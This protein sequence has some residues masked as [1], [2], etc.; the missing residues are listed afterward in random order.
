MEPRLIQIIELLRHI[1]TLLF[2][3]LGLIALLGGF[4][5]ADIVFGA[6]LQVSPTYSHFNYEGI[7]SGPGLKV[8]VSHDW[9]RLWGS[10]QHTCRTEH[11]QE[12]GKLELLGVG[13]GVQA[14]IGK[15]LM[16]CIDVGY[17]YPYINPGSSANEAMFLY[18][19]N[20]L[21]ANP[22]Y[23]RYEYDVSGNIGGSIGVKYSRAGWFLGV[24]Y[25]FLRCHERISAYHSTGFVSFPGYVDYGSFIAGLG[26]EF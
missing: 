3:I 16:F 1:K 23:G 8:A 21:P 14:D 22:V 6:E 9:F 26:I 19:V 15:N 24:D 18:I 7:E 13:L 11:R 4:F 25:T 20:Q 2:F 10:W 5:V 12:L 17:F